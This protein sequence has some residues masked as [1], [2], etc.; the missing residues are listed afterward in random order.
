ME[1][2]SSVYW[3]LPSDLGRRALAAWFRSGGTDQPREPEGRRVDGKEYVVLANVRGILACYRVRNDGK[4][5][6][7]ARMPRAILEE[8]G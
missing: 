7:L 8:W 5:K 2:K 6:S 1:M 4:L 3:R